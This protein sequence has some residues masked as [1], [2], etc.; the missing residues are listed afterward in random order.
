M[1][2]LNIRM[3]RID[4]TSEKQTKLRK[5]NVQESVSAFVFK[6]NTKKNNDQASYTLQKREET[7]FAPYK[8]LKKS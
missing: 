3:S 5:Q 2:M 6:I 4:I 8:T 1:L 7:T